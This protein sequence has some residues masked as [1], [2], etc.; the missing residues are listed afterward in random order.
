MKWTSPVF[1][2]FCPLAESLEPHHYFTYLLIKSAKVYILN[3][4]AVNASKGWHAKTWPQC[5]ARLNKASLNPGM[6]ERRFFTAPAIF[7]Y[8]L[9]SPLSQHD[10]NKRS[11]VWAI[12]L[13]LLPIQTSVCCKLRSC[14]GRPWCSYQRRADFHAFFLLIID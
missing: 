12:D 1:L 7:Q 4:V 14:T 11:S 10:S 8:R 5:A 13:V 6:N 9:Q 2:C 3:V